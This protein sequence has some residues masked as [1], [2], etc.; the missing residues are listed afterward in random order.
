MDAEKQKILDFLF[1]YELDKDKRYYYPVSGDLATGEEV[2]DD[3]LE[4]FY[5]KDKY[6]LWENYCIKD[7]SG[8]FLHEEMTDEDL[9][10][11]YDEDKN[12][13]E[14]FWNIWTDG[15]SLEREGEE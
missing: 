14:L 6:V 11:K 7:L 8:G 15:N 2:V 9:E 10:K 13:V 12:D 5:G 4:F 3:F 1:E